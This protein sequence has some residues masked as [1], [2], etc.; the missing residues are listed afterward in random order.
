MLWRSAIFLPMRSFIVLLA[1]SVL[2]V[3]AADMSEAGNAATA[4]LDSDV[5]I[6]ES[7]AADVGLECVLGE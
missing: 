1:V 4:L 7:D 6:A 2:G 3:V 5:V